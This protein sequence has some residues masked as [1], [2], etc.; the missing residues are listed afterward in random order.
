MFSILREKP[1][2]GSTIRGDLQD[3]SSPQLVQLSDFP[4][5]IFAEEVSFLEKKPC[6]LLISKKGQV[7]PIVFGKQHFRRVYYSVFTVF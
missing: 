6:I 2:D 4:F 7:L 1:P 5:S 3:L